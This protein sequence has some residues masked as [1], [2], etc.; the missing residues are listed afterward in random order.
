MNI[1]AIIGNVIDRCGGDLIGEKLPSGIATLHVLNTLE[2]LGQELANTFKGTFAL[3]ATET[4]IEQTGQLETTPVFLYRPQYVRYRFTENSPSSHGIGWQ[5][6]FVLNDVEEITHAEN[7][8]RPAIWFYGKHPF[9]YQLSFEPQGGIEVEIWGQNVSSVVAN[10][11]IVPQIPEEFS[12]YVAL[13]AAMIFLDDLLLLRDAAKYQA[14]FSARKQTMM[15]EV[16]IPKKIWTNFLNRDEN[17]NLAMTIE[18]FDIFSDNYDNYGH[19]GIVQA[20]L[21]GL[22]GGSA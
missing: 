3:K 18:P 14:F 21:D 22:D 9:N 11:S 5:E 4:L 15:E 12:Q 10:L 1:Q 8:A 19:S 20:D 2:I 17:R 6:L 13:R 16:K 7:V